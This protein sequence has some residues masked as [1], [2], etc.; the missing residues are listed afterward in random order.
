MKIN[1]F[2]IKQSMVGNEA[3]YYNQAVMNSEKCHHTPSMSSA[4][5]KTGLNRGSNPEPLHHG[6]RLYPLSH[7]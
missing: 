6:S 1:I 7:I 4:P 2:F 3:I 5:T